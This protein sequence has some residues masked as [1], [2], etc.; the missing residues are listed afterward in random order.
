MTP[1]AEGGRRGRQDREENIGGGLKTGYQDN[2]LALLEPKT[3]DRAFLL[4][5]MID[6]ERSPV[7]GS[8]LISREEKESFRLAAC[9]DKQDV[10]F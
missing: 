9:E 2:H 6:C 3:L 4:T 8:Y 10:Q 7:I 1:H 5:Q